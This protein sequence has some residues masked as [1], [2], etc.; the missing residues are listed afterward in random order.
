MLLLNE[1]ADGPLQGTKDLAISYSPPPHPTPFARGSTCPSGDSVLRRCPSILFLSLG[2]I[3]RSKIVKTLYGNT[4]SSRRALLVS[5]RPSSLLWH[6]H[7]H[8]FPHPA[9]TAS[10]LMHIVNC[11]SFVSLPFYTT[12]GFRWKCSYTS[13]VWQGCNEPKVFLTV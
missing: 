6:F 10:G 1:M 4:R 3:M 2:W 8:P 13:P 5:P 7:I 12:V 9:A 11:V